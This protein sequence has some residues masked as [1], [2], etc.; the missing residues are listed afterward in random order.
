MKKAEYL[1]RR[2]KGQA[3]PR[4]SGDQVKFDLGGSREKSPHVKIKTVPFI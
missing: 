3:K 2:K 1:E 4:D